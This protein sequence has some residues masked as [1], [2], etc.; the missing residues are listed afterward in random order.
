MHNNP[1]LLIL[2]KKLHKNKTVINL[3]ISLS[4]SISKLHKNQLNK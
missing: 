4:P 2:K 3:Q 1:I